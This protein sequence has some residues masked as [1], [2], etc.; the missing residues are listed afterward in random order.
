MK[1][2]EVQMRYSFENYEQGDQN[3]SIQGLP[4]VRAATWIVE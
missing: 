4:T 1:P 2:P 3:G